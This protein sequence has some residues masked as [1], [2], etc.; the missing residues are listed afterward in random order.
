MSNDLLA[1]RADTLND[2]IYGTNFYRIDR[3]NIE[4]DSKE[5]V[6]DVQELLL[7]SKFVF[8]TKQYGFAEDLNGQLLM[9]FDFVGKN[10]KE[11]SN[12]SGFFQHSPEK[13]IQA[14]YLTWCHNEGLP[15]LV[16][17]IPYDPHQA[18]YVAALHELY[19]RK[20]DGKN[21]GYITA[22]TNYELNS[23]TSRLK[24]SNGKKLFVKRMTRLY[25]RDGFARYDF[26]FSE[27]SFNNH[28]GEL[29]EHEETRPVA[30]MID[31]N[32]SVGMTL[33]VNKTIG[34]KYSHLDVYNDQ[35]FRTLID[36]NFANTSDMI[37]QRLHED[38][39][40]QV[41]KLVIAEDSKDPEA[42]IESFANRL[43]KRDTA[44]S[45]VE[46]MSRAGF[47]FDFALHR[48]DGDGTPSL[49]IGKH[50]DDGRNPL[51][52]DGYNDQTGNEDPDP[53]PE[54]AEPLHG[55][56]HAIQTPFRLIGKLST[57]FNQ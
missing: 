26:E 6:I 42:E 18:R 52:S 23:D 5:L 1:Q 8:R 36:A 54:D 25:P 38:A 43:T 40:R 3:D 24:I 2:Y 15:H 4:P 19:A 50:R 51:H 57:E 30:D 28:P 44:I 41:F 20:D 33:S 48:T 32:Y 16:E 17:G 22:M 46:W 56:P 55:N 10:Y 29:D 39:D 31:G 47:T 11:V 45:L 9:Y 14:A 13:V 34:K 35:K 37:K 27:R 21:L 53:Y 12:V 49:H 7:K